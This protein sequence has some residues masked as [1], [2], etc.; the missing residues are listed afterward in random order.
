MIQ[1]DEEQKNE[2]WL[3]NL[4]SILIDNG[5]SSFLEAI[6]KPIHSRSLELER[7]CLVTLAWL[8]KATSPFDVEFKL[9]KAF[10]TLIYSLK[11]TLQ[12][13]NEVE[14]KIFASMALLNFSK[15]PGNKHP[16]L[17]D[18]NTSNHFI[19]LKFTFA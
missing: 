16:I 10:S 7:A 12:K 8:S 15:I 4:A 5:K 6:S 11:D 1:D 18:S 3:R 14:H 2:E 19:A 13:A 17:F 9:S